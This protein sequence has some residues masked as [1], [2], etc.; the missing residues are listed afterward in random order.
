MNYTYY[1]RYHTP[2]E[3]RGG[4]RSFFWLVFGLVFIL[5]ILRACVSIGQTFFEEKK[6]EALLVLSQGEA[7][8]L[9]WGQSDYKPVADAQLLLLGDQVRTRE[10]S[11]LTI[12]FYN[13]TL[14]RLG[15][16]S[17]LLLSD[18]TESEKSEE[19]HVDLLQGRA[20]VEQPLSDKGEIQL[21]FKTALLQ[22][23]SNRAEYFLE[24]SDVR[25]VV[26][27]S[28]GKL[29]VN[30]MDPSSDNLVIETAEL[31]PGE[32]TLLTA[33]R[34]TA[35]LARENISL[36][37]PVSEEILSEAQNVDQSASSMK[38]PETVGPEASGVRTVDAELLESG[39]VL[40]IS[41]LSPTSGTTVQ[42]DAIAIE[43]QI[44]NGTA[45]TVTVTWSGSGVPY[46]LSAFNPGSSSFRYVADVDYQNFTR[47]QNTYTIVAYNEE[48]QSSNTLTVLI[49]AEF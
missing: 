30:F 29:T 11:E 1:R 44:T 5:L 26:Y 33:E 7:E 49:N 12:T 20:W 2:R 10:N 37:E 31:S 21:L 25:E 48:G 28:E 36:V 3:R 42:K 22:L 41:L 32:M 39:G 9:E 47:G 38:A 45:Q 14:I 15:K 6:D 19:V 16:N 8:I 34:E 23:Q 35:L 43:G 4:F 18:V 46:T 24:N 40:Q 13:G 17:E 27:L